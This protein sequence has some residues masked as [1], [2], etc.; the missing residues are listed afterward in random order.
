MGNDTN[1]IQETKE[2]LDKRFNIKDLG[3][4]KYFLGIEVTCVPEGLVLSQRKYI[5]DILDDCGMQGCR[6]SSFPI[7][8]NLKLDKGEKESKVDASQYRRIAGRLLYL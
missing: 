6:P 4:L 7:K 8:Q 1:K 5:L 2:V 3:N